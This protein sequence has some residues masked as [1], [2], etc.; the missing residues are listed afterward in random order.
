[1]VKWLINAS[2][3][4]RMRLSGYLSD[5]ESTSDPDNSELTSSS[6]DYV[7]TLSDASNVTIQDESN[8]APG[9][10]P[11]Q[12]EK[13]F[14]GSVLQSNNPMITITAAENNSTTVGRC[15]TALPTGNE[16]CSST[17]E[18]STIDNSIFG[19]T[20]ENNFESIGSYA[21]T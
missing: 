12:N 19:V 6:S 20:A 5:K 8:L 14:S 1:M 11:T 17:N 3:L 10:L 13:Y 9:E 18:T 21:N 16:E 7:D 2:M 15:I 4:N